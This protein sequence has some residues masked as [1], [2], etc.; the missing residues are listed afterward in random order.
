MIVD[1]FIIAL[2]TYKEPL[3][4]KDKIAERFPFTLANCCR[5]MKVTN[6]FGKPQGL[7]YDWGQLQI[8]QSNMGI[9]ISQE[10]YDTLDDI[11]IDFFN[12]YN[13]KVITPKG[14][15]V[16]FTV[17][18]PESAETIFRNKCNTFKNKKW[19]DILDTFLDVLV[20]F[21]KTATVHGDT[22]EEWH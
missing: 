12:S 8:F 1:A 11:I 16:M 5:T 6:I 4:T 14:Q 10:K 22:L 21:L 13:Y 20:E 18:F 2:R 17:E 3:Y 19:N 9:A 15:H 7:L